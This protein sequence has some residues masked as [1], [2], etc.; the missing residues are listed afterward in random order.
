MTTGIKK[1][2]LT[3]I[4]AT[5]LT[6]FT[7][8]CYSPV[9]SQDYFRQATAD[10]PVLEPLYSTSLYT[11]YFDHAL[12]RCVVHSSYSWGE[13]GG[14]GGGTGIGIEAFRCD[15]NRIRAR[16]QETGIKVYPPKRE[17]VI[18]S[19]SNKGVQK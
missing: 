2:R 15:P 4:A 18:P 16:A 13:K 9:E 1:P 14:G 5:L 12:R 19:Q 10:D 17:L 3:F 7:W 8:G 6:L 11:V